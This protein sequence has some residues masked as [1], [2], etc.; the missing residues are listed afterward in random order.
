MTFGGTGEFHCKFS[1]TC[2]E[3]ECGYLP[4]SAKIAECMGRLIT[5]GNLFL[6]LHLHGCSSGLSCSKSGLLSPVDKLLRYTGERCLLFEQ[7]GPE[8]TFPYRICK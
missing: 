3:A 2:S 1:G 5:E 8:V 6:H 7:L 4:A